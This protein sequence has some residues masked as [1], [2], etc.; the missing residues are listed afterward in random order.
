MFLRLK[1]QM[2]KS[3]EEQEKQ[4]SNDIAQIGFLRVLTNE[5]L[6]QCLPGFVLVLDAHVQIGVDGRDDGV[7]GLFR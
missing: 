2:E 6:G 3:K 5:G 7:N 1:I 4:A